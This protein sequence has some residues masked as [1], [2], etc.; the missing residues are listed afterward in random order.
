MTT[1]E[2]GAKL[3][4][5]QGWER[6]PRS[7]AFLARMPDAIITA[8][9]DV[10]VQ[11]VMAAMATDPWPNST[12]VPSKV[13]KTLVSEEGAAVATPEVTEVAAFFFDSNITGKACRQTFWE[14]FKVTRSCGRRGPA[15]L[16]SIEERSRE[17][18]SEKEGSGV[19]SVRNN[20][21]ALV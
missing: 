13:T 5:T 20:P 12:F 17:R 1:F 9:F 16:G 3:V 2:P 7:T 15:M 11:L 8:G 21:W 18:V 4:F 14:S 19:S 6:S 10:F